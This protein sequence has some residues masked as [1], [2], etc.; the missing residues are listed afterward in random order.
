[1]RDPGDVPAAADPLGGAGGGRLVP[2][3]D[4]GLLAAVLLPQ[5]ARA[6]RHAALHR[7]Q[8]VALG[9]HLLGLHRLHQGVYSR[10][11][12]LLYLLEILIYLFP[13]LGRTESPWPR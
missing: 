13:G 1:M 3:H 8:P 4:A 12:Y 5:H 9:R 7:P 6:L 11:I 10:Y 2:G